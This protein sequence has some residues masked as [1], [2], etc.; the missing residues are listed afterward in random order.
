[1]GCTREKPGCDRHVAL[2]GS[3]SSS[4]FSGKGNEFTC[5]TSG[6]TREKPG[7]E[8]H[9]TMFA[10][11]SSF[12]KGNEFVCDTAGC[13]REKPGCEKHRGMFSSSLGSK[14]FGT[15]MSSSSSSVTV[16]PPIHLGREVLPTTHTT[17]VV[18]NTSRP[19]CIGGEVLPTT[20]TTSVLPPQI[21][22]TERH[23]VEKIIQ[24]MERE[25][26]KPTEVT[27]EKPIIN[28]ERH[29]HTTEVQP[30]IQPI[31]REDQHS[32]VVPIEQTVHGGTIHNKVT[33]LPDIRP[34]NVIGSNQPLPHHS[35]TSATTSTTT[36]GSTLPRR[37]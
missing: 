31:L 20:H 34:T 2:F 22:P 8:K 37:T 5:D 33:H 16:A 32:K 17:S 26:V 12:G 29:I 9:K 11:S 24:P 1:M 15:G 4:G 21:N 27:Y 35:A 18:G 30:V 25:I 3:S 36:S 10:S 28:E 14:G 19:K 6:C 13:T 23:T 7:C